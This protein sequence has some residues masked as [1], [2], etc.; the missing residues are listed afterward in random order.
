MKPR[1]PDPP[2]P[3]DARAYL[4]GHHRAL[5]PRTAH[6]LLGPVPRGV[7]RLDQDLSQGPHGVLIRKPRTPSACYLQAIYRQ[8]GPMRAPAELRIGWRR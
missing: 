6:R 4:G 2:R 5:P 3:A 7:R 8:T 1:C